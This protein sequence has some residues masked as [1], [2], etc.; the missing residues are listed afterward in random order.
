MTGTQIVTEIITIL[1]SALKPFG[2]AIGEAL[3]SMATSIFL[4]VTGTGA[5]ATTTLS[6]FGVLIIVFAAISL[7]VGLSRWVLN[8]V[9]SLGG[10]NR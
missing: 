1:V 5:D 6:T 2:Q 3:S 10:R 7:A 8:F 9:T 4:Q